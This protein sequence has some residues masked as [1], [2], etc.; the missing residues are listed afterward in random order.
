MG[1]VFKSCKKCTK[2]T[3]GCQS[4]CKDYAADKKRHEE[5]M[6]A[7]KYDDEIEHY[8]ARQCAENLNK[9]AKQKQQ[10][11]KYRVR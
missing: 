3:I 5:L 8:R 6:E 10:Y 7:L 1:T 2:R 4:W 11:N 9:K